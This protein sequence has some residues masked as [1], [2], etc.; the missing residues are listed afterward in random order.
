ML[1]P[2]TWQILKIEQRSRHKTASEL[3]RYSILKTF[4]NLETQLKLVR[5]EKAKIA[6][7]LS[8]IQQREA[9]LVEQFKHRLGDKWEYIEFEINDQVRHEV[10]KLI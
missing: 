3:V 5:I 2:I 10:E 8:R 4:K 1:D 6:Q 7:K 9:Q